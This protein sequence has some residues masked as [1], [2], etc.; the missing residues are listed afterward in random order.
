[1]TDTISRYVLE[2]GPDGGTLREM[3]DAE[4]AAVCAEKAANTEALAKEEAVEMAQHLLNAS[5]W[6]QLGDTGLTDACKAAFVTYRAN[7]RA[8]RKNP[9]VDPTWPTKPTEEWT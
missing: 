9:T 3:D 7:L 6:T 4:Y 8:I 2:A 1:M 5:D